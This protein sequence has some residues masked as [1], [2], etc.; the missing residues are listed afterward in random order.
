MRSIE[1]W[2]LPTRVFHWA[3]VALV[4]FDLVVAEDE[5]VALVLH[6]FAGYLVLLLLVFRLAWGVVGGEHALFRDFVAPWSG[7][8]E[9]AGRLATRDPLPRY[10]GHN[11]LGGWMIVLM[12]VTLAVIVL[13]GLAIHDEHGGS[14]PISAFVSPGLAE[15]AEELHEGAANF[16]ILLIAVHI[17]GVIA[18]SVLEGENLT[19]AM[20]TGRES[21]EESSPLRDARRSSASLA[22]ALTLVLAV[23]GGWLVANTSFAD[24]ERPIEEE[25]DEGRD[26]DHEQDRDDD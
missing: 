5:G 26:Q 16:M 6:T 2:D 8:R 7:V 12:L 19:R 1:V 25:H 18:T 21:A 4:L 14:G 22:V 13:S 24:S 10:V 23:L 20:I 3:L 9:Y 17:V 15:A 11:P